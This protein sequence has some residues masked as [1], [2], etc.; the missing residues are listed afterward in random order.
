MRVGIN[1]RYLQKPQ[2]GI[3]N[4]LFNTLLSLSQLP[5]DNE[6]FLFF[7]RSGQIPEALRKPRFND[8][9]SSISCGNQL[10]K[11]IWASLYLPILAKRYKLDV[12]HEPLFIA[13]LHKPCPTVIT[14]YDLAFMRLSDSYTWRTK[15]YLRTLIARSIKEADAV[16]TISESSKNDIINQ[17]GYPEKLHVIYGGV[18]PEFHKLS[19]PPASLTINDK[20]IHGDYILNVSLITPRKNMVS[21]IRAY[22]LFRDKHKVDCKL[23]IAGGRGW[24][25][26]DVYKEAERSRYAK[27]IIFCGY[28]TREELIWLYNSAKAFV[29]PSLYEGFGLP[30]LEAMACGCPV[31]TS[32]ISSLPEVCGD[33]ALLVEPLDIEDLSGAIQKVFFSESLRR[34]MVEKGFSRASRFSWHKSAKETAGIYK[35]VGVG[36]YE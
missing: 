18:D 2:T 30:V 29:Y 10:I 14:V 7:D 31:V 35:K 28:V 1:A 24:G 34:G 6:Y 25:W 4:Y 3:E 11:V 32:N 8:V 19:V 13:P 20:L 21:L 36:G 5:E 33:A 15:L 23:V 9:V 26:K 22:V 12:F 16:I 27:D 17:F